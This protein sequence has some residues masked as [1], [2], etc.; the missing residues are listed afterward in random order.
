MVKGVPAASLAYHNL[1]GVLPDNDETLFGEETRGELGDTAE[2]DVT[3]D[4]EAGDDGDN[5]SGSARGSRTGSDNVGT[6]SSRFRYHPRAV[7]E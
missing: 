2:A 7:L 4:G 3:A 1:N 5:G 6:G